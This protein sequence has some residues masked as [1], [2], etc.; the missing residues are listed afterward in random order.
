MG[1]RFSPAGPNNMSFS[2]AYSDF[3]RSTRKLANAG[4]TRDKTPEEHKKIMD[5][6][7]KRQRKQ[8]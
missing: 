6:Y 8:K 4:L 1:V 7:Y 2:K 3:K 5:E